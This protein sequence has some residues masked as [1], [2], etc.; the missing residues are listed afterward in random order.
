MT[1]LWR[2]RLLS[3]SGENWWSERFCRT[4]QHEAPWNHTSVEDLT[5]S[6]INKQGPG[7]YLKHQSESYITSVT[8]QMWQSK[9]CLTCSDGD[10][11]I[12]DEESEL[13]CS[14]QTTLL[15]ISNSQSFSGLRTC[16]VYLVS[17]MVRDIWNGNSKKS[18]MLPV[19]R[20]LK[21][22]DWKRGSSYDENDWVRL[23]TDL[24]PMHICDDCVAWS[25]YGT[26]SE[27]GICL[28]LFHWLWDPIPRT[29][30]PCPALIQDEV[31]SLTTTW[32]AMFCWHPWE[33]CTSLNTNR[34]VDRGSRE[35]VG[36]AT[37]RKEGRAT[38]VGC[39][40]N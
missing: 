23:L 2:R 27:S 33:P 20:T 32:Y 1:S 9:T 29:W 7:N 13:L 8:G 17:N 3:L 21:L 36:G 14:V 15:T 26:N 25:S 35:K 39:K 37:W 38:V 12:S 10:W 34:G 30:L 22:P 31:L 6:I 16:I 11:T 28:W 4:G 40:I 24:D 5:V 18:Q 19:K